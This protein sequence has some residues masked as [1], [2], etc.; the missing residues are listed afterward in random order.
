[1]ENNTSDKEVLVRGIRLLAFALP[2]IFTGPALYF[3]V[4]THQGWVWPTV[5]I[6]IMALAVYLVVKGI[7]TLIKGFFGS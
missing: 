7:R 1:M 4:G 5:A 6:G 3:A 2:L